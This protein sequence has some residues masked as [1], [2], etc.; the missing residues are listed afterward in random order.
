MSK[1]FNSSFCLV[2]LVNCS[3]KRIIINH[4][5]NKLEEKLIEI[6][7]EF[8]NIILGRKTGVI[9]NSIFE[10]IV[11]FCEDFLQERKLNYKGMAYKIEDGNYT[12]IK[13]VLDKE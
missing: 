2:N 1:E 9:N 13:T 10:N 11:N 6:K 12:L 5:N 8:I 7:Q 4:S 3:L